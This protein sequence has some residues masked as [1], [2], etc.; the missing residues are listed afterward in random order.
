MANENETPE[1]RFKRLATH[2]TNEVLDRLRV[3]GHCANRQ[4]YAYSQEQVNKIFAAIEKQLK[5][6]RAK[7]HY[8]REQ[9][10]KL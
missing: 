4:N 10:F 8:S 1:Q 5:E 9:R 2:R 3:L 6:V 7:F